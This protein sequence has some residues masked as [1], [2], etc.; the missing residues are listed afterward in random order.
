MDEK[1]PTQHLIFNEKTTGKVMEFYETLENQLLEVLRIIPFEKQNFDVWSPKLISIFL[2]SCSIIDS[3]FK[4]TSRSKEKIYGRIIKRT[5]LNM[6][7][8]RHLYRNKF[9]LGDLNSLMYVSPPVVLAPFKEWMGKGSG[10]NPNWWQDH[11]RVKHDRLNNMNLATIKNTVNAVCGLFQVISQHPKMVIA[12]IRY[13]WLSNGGYAPDYLIRNLS[14]IKRRKETN[15]IFL[16]ETK[17]FVTTIGKRSFPNNVKEINPLYYKGGMVRL[18]N[19]L[20]R[21]S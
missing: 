6:N 18:N 3:I 10:Q 15:D 5:D 21:I 13:R 2:D 17:L 1:K 16:V 9:S 12:I 8:F 20:G 11:Q 4:T 19:F 7:H 14:S